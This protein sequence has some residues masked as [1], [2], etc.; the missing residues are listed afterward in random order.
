MVSIAP[1]AL[2]S[3]LL[4]GTIRHR[5]SHVTT[6]DFTHHVWYLALDLAE[7]DEVDRRL[8]LLSVNRRNVLSVLDRD[9]LEHG[10]EGLRDTIARRLRACGLDPNQTRVTLIAYPRV[11]GYVF[12]PVS[13]YLCHDRNDVLSLVL[14][15]VHNTHGDRETYEFTPIESNGSVFKGV[16]DKRMYVSPFIAPVARYEL[17]VSEANDRLAITIR[18]REGDESTLFARL[19]LERAPLT[20]GQLLRLVARDPLVPLKTSALIFWH[21]LRLWWRGV[22]WRRYPGSPPPDVKNGE[23]EHGH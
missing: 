12:N 14:A 19:Q 11:L 6:Y 17:Q 23:F 4:A 1:G 21:A 20:D 5:R 10:H 22:P 18:E 9:H 3:H 13:F 2:R 8:R 15:E 7:L 16:A